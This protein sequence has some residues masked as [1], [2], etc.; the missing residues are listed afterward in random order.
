MPA[1]PRI[2]YRIFFWLWTSFQVT[3]LNAQTA[4]F[5]ASVTEGCAPLVVNF[6]DQSTGSNL[7]YSWDFGNGNASSQQNPGA[8]YIQGGTYTVKL[9]VWNGSGSDSVIKTAYI[10]VF[11][12]PKADFTLASPV[13][14]CVPVQVHFKDSTTPGNYPITSWVWDFGDGSVSQV[15]NP[16]HTYSLAGEHTVSLQV[17]DSKG[18]GSSISKTRYLR[19]NDPF[20]FTFSPDNPSGCSAPLTTGFSVNLSGGQ[21]PF[22]YD[23]DF[24]D[25]TGSSQNKPQK[26]YTGT[27]TFDVSLKIT[28]ASGCSATRTIKAAISTKG[29]KAAFTTSVNDGCVPLSVRFVDASTPSP[30]QAVYWESG[31]FKSRSAD[32]TVVFTQPGIYSVTWMV[33]RNGCGD[34]VQEHSRINVKESPQATFVADDTL[35]CGTRDTVHFTSQGVDVKNYLWDFDGGH[36]PNNTWPNP[37]VVFT[38]TNRLFDIQLTVFHANG[39]SKVISK[40]GYIRQVVTRVEGIADTV[41]ACWP[42]PVNFSTWHRSLFPPKSWEW[43]FGNG[44][45]STD[46]NPVY[47]YPDTGAYMAAV[48]L[49]DQ[50]GCVAIDSVYVSRGK[51]PKAAF[52]LDSTRGCSNSLWVQFRNQSRDSSESYIDD[53]HWD[54]GDADPDVQPNVKDWEPNVHYHVPPGKKTVT[55]TVISR[56]CKDSLVLQDAVEVLSPHADVANLTDPCDPLRFKGI[57]TSQYGHLFDWYLSD[58]SYFRTDS[59]VHDFQQTGWQVRFI[60]SDTLTQCKDTL[61]IGQPYSEYFYAIPKLEVPKCAPAMV[62]FKTESYNVQDLLYEFSNGFSTHDTTFG[63]LVQEPGKLSFTLTVTSNQGCKKVYHDS[64]SI[65]LLGYKAEGWLEHDS[66]CIPDSLILISGVKSGPGIRDVFWDVA[67]IGRIPADQDT[68]SVWIN[69][70]PYPQRYGLD[71]LLKVED[72]SGCVSSKV[73]KAFPFRPL[74]AVTISEEPGCTQTNYRFKIIN[75]GTAGYEIVNYHWTFPGGKTSSYHEFLTP[76]QTGVW[77]TVTLNSVDRFGCENNDTFQ[78]F[79]RKGSLVAN[80]RAAPTYSSCPPLLVSFAD[81]SYSRTDPIVKWE[82][83]FGDGTS[84]LLRNPKKNYLVPGK[85]TVKLKV[86]DAKGCVDTKEFPDMVIVDGPT[87]TYR[88]SPSEACENLEATFESTTQGASKIEWDLGDGNLGSGATVHHTYPN[89][90]RYIPLMILSNDQGCTYALPPIDTIFVRQSPHALFLMEADCPG[91]PS[92]FIHIGSSPEGRITEVDWLIDQTLSADDSIVN[93]SFTQSGYHP[94]RLVVGTEYGCRDTFEDQVAVPG[95][96]A[97]AY[98]A[99]TGLCLGSPTWFNANLQFFHDDLD[100][101]HWHFGDGTEQAGRDSLLSHRYDLIGRYSPKLEVTSQ[102][103]CSSTVTLTD[104]V[105]GDTIAPV[106]PEIYRISVNDAQQLFLEHKPSTRVDFV[107]YQLDL[108]ERGG[109]FFEAA[110]RYNRYDT[111]WLH[112]SLDVR[113]RVYEMRLRERNACGKISGPSQSSLHGSIELRTQA[114]TNVVNLAWNTYLG[115]PGVAFYRV[116]REDPYNPGQFH[117]IAEISGSDSSFVDSTFLCYATPVYRVQGWRSDS[118]L[119]SQS[120]TA[121]D[122]PP[123]LPEVPQQALKRISVENDKGVLA[124]WTTPPFSR[125]PVTGYLLEYSSNGI[126]FIPEKDWFP[127]TRYKEYKT[128]LAVDDQS[129]WFRIR[130]VDSCGDIGPPGKES[131]SILLRTSMD[132]LERPY[133]EWSS[134]LGWEKPPHHYLVERMEP[135]GSI[136]ELAVLAPTDSSYTDR[137]TEDAGRADYC[138]RI[139]AF[140]EDGD[141]RSSGQVW[142][143]SNISC[144]PVVSRI[145][146]PNAFTPNHDLL[147]DRFEVKGMYIREYRIRIYNRWGQ[148]LFESQ[149]FRNDWDGTYKEVPSQEDVYMYMID[150]VGTDGKVYHLKGNLTLLP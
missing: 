114:D 132:S 64:G 46:Q 13:Q 41:R 30:M 1:K 116:Q 22:T 67:G 50:K 103:G 61:D 57:N 106:A 122:A 131:R 140:L 42:T 128:P 58:G 126:D 135:D 118:L 56:G 137:I 149:R 83:D 148:L 144:A 94:V 84:S 146:V 32:T 127:A 51:K 98:S 33:F 102:R 52:T 53:W 60:V 75:Y 69:H 4:D 111:T 63:V 6:T 120:D 71:V 44:D 77:N 105:V 34:T 3:F 115:W 9:K 62:Q 96:L 89:P 79:G 25:G 27:G 48:K 82:W 113:H 110:T 123:Y 141:Y 101:L 86:T 20:Q 93:Y 139:T 45:K 37:V 95:I 39:C 14:G 8:I 80:L 74:P 109:S 117:T 35:L 121:K 97:M 12:K 26:T 136:V 65:S 145:F 18:C 119:F 24:G 23:W 5:S 38:D 72:D 108:R 85:Y 28:D 90:G 59:L 130:C 11:P 129:Y 112:P 15:Q 133:L 147:N 99:D 43:D 91:K 54:F 10:R 7:S 124:E 49:T 142:S 55:L 19:V 66:F 81:S 68:L 17:T 47:I 36:T 92:K 104:I 125:F 70:T 138:Y 76:L 100:T 87:G 40:P 29:P 78:I 73:L 88:L 150:A 2:T 107:N 134:Y 16:S 21:P 143:H 31:P